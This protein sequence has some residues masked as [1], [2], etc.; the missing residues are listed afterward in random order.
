MGKVD[1]RRGKIIELLTDNPIISLTE[2]AKLLNVTTETIRSDLKSPQ[3]ADSVVQA[4]GSVALAH[5]TIARDIP[6]SFRKEINFKVKSKIAEKACQLIKP[7]QVIVI[8]HNSISVVLIHTLTQYPHL[9]NNITIITNSFSIMQYVQEKRLDVHI[10]FLGGTFSLAQENSYGSTTLNQMKSL[11]ADLA[12]LSPGAINEA[13]E[14]TAY[15]ERDADL[16]KEIIKNSSQSVLLIE[17]SKY[18]SIAMWKVNQASDYHAII[19]E[20][21]FTEEQKGCLE[22]SNVQILNI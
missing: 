15:K 17:K 14:I 1:T 12:F 22:K 21:T 7:G 11:K 8:E 4:H 20:I 2:L 18:P 6:Y 10:V 13:L 3:L 5:T 16:Q 19:T 9:L